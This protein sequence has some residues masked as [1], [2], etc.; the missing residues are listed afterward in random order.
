LMT[1]KDLAGSELSCEKIL[2][3]LSHMKGPFAETILS[4][5]VPADF[6]WIAGGRGRFRPF[7]HTDINV[8][9]IRSDRP[10]IIICQLSHW[11]GRF[12]CLSSPVKA[13]FNPHSHQQSHCQSA[14]IWQVFTSRCLRWR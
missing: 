3:S 5:M 1:I 7:V 12:I 6:K 8:S 2:A 10:I 13:S 9:H 14:L 4:E 11:L